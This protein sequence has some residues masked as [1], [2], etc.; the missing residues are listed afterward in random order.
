M[1]LFCGLG[2]ETIVHLF[3]DCP[4]YVQ[5]FIYGYNSSAFIVIVL[6]LQPLCLSLEQN[7]VKTDKVIDL[8]ILLSKFHIDL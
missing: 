2:E 1:C 8:L 7:Y 6:L 5:M 3:W 4:Y